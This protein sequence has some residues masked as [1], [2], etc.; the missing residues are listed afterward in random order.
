MNTIRPLSKPRAFSLIEVVIALS[1]F[2]FGLV[3]LL[4]LF[5]VGLETFR[6]SK[7]KVMHGEIIKLLSSEF[8]SMRFDQ[9]DSLNGKTYLFAEDGTPVTNS[10]NSIY[11][12]VV[13]ILKTN[14]TLPTGNNS[15]VP[16]SDCSTV[17]IR[18]TQVTDPSP[19]RY[20]F[21]IAN[22]GL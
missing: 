22:R 2:S 20:N 18:I 15:S 6:N 4:G 10:T 13:E 3:A 17:Q 7:Q 9:L 21:L 19:R 5:P 16:L 12:A 11:Q 14:T 8:S 1:I